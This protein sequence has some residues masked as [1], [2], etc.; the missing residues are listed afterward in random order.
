MQAIKDLKMAMFAGK[1]V[2][3]C[4]ADMREGTADVDG[5]MKLELEA[6]SGKVFSIDGGGDAKSATDQSQ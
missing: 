2:T 4:M 5:K 6:W 3:N 1:A